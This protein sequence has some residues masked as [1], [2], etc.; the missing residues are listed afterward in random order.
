MIGL[1]GQQPFSSLEVDIIFLIYLRN[2]GS[3]LPLFLDLI[4]SYSLDLEVPIALASLSLQLNHT[5]DCTTVPSTLPHHSLL[6]THTSLSLCCTGSHLFEL[7][8]IFK[9]QSS[10]FLPDSIS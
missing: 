10:F 8:G 7:D 3:L 4:F 5:Q 2:N 1:K 9:T 6:L